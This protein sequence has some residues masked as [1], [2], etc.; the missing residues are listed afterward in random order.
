MKSLKLF[1][2]VFTSLIV[3]MSSQKS[4][5]TKTPNTLKL[6]WSTNIGNLSY[7]SNIVLSENALF[8]GSNGSHFNDVNALD[9][10]SG[11]YKI[12]RKTGSVISRMGNELFGDMDVNG[13][14]KVGNTIIFGNDNEEL[15]C[16]DFEGNK[17]WRI[18]VSGDIEHVPT[19]ISFKQ[20]NIVVFATES[21]EVRAVNSE[22]GNT[23]WNYYHEKFDGWKIG[24]HRNVFKVK[25]HFYSNQLFFDKPLIEDIND[26]GISD[27]IYYGEYQIICLNG[28]NG[29]K[30]WSKQIQLQDKEYLERRFP[31]N[32]S[33]SN[34]NIQI[35]YISS[36]F[37]TKKSKLI[38]LNRYGKN[39]KEEDLNINCLSNNYI[40]N[41][42]FDQKGIYNTSKGKFY[43]VNVSKSYTFSTSQNFFI[44][45]NEPCVAIIENSSFDYEKHLNYNAQI[46]IVGLESLK[47][48][49]VKNIEHDTES[50]PQIADI[51][52]DGN[53]D[54]LVGCYN[55]KIYCYDL[56][57]PAS[58]LL[59]N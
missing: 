24:D 23:I 27:L 28:L 40:S 35:H 51:N 22:N 12:N 8:I 54:V 32:I 34:N 56:G 50:V 31:L 49:L 48:H 38:S 43:P 45:N 14:L 19:L 29:K 17:K 4:V 52:Q 9:E 58:N 25:M 2:I 15:L 53:L 37:E 5:K 47:T 1:I 26:D 3:L 59:N 36:N 41:Y 7:R 10:T 13:V 20:N 11:V 57:I 46:K 21:G 16:Y 30:I 42:I 6:I 39:L 55:H 18:P 33:S 44:Y